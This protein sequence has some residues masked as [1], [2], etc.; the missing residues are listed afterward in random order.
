[1]GKGPVFTSPERIAE[2]RS[3]G[4]RVADLEAGD[5]LYFPSHWYHEVHNLTSDTKAV[6]NS[7]P[8][9]ADKKERELQA[10]EEH[11]KQK[12]NFEEGVKVILNNQIT[13]LNL[14]FNILSK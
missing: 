11:E 9:P 8:W 12:P 10:E 5:L 1:M 2:G 13:T 14:Q 7:I 3:L 6:T 4:L